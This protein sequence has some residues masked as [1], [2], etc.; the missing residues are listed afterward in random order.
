MIQKLELEF[1]STFLILSRQNVDKFL[2]MTLLPAGSA[3]SP[4]SP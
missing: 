4:T 2:I 1:I 3:L